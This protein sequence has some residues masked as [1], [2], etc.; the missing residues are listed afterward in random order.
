VGLGFDPSNLMTLGIYYVLFLFSYSVPAYISG[1]V[2]SSELVVN[3]LVLCIVVKCVVL[4]IVFMLMCTVLLPLGVDPIA[5]N[6]YIISYIITCLLC[7][8][9]CCLMSPSS[10][11]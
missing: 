9:I 6:K 10:L 1:T 3:F 4:C 7:N 5:V 11:L 8:H 2:N